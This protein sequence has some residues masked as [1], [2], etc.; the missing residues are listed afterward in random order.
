MK[1]KGKDGFK[2][3]AICLVD[4]QKVRQKNQEMKVLMDQMRNLVWD[5]NAMLTLRK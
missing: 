5:V 3:F 2:L 4:L 1:K